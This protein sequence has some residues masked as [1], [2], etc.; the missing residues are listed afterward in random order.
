MLPTI[1]DYVPPAREEFPVNRVEWRIDPSR[2]VL[3]V[4]DMQQYFVDAYGEGSRAASSA[5]ANIQQLRAA[6]QEAGVPVYFT[7]QPP[8][9]RLED[10]RLLWDFWGPGIQDDGRHVIVDSL[11]PVAEESLITKWRYDAFVRTDLQERIQDAGRD[12]L[13]VTGIY[14]H[15]GVLMTA[16]SAFMRDIQPFLV[17]DAVADFSLDYHR[18]A[19]R[20]AAERCAVV[21]DSDTALEQL[22][23]GGTPARTIASGAAVSTT[24]S[25][26]VADAV[27]SGTVTPGVTP[28]DA[29]V[30]AAAS[31]G[32]VAAGAAPSSSAAEFVAATTST[33][34]ESSVTAGTV[35]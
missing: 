28:G 19:L 11:R 6:A 5:I 33:A 22:A 1:A 14:A 2:A 25:T 32:I 3:L 10:R 17:A 26:A 29:E 13:I 20:Y 12:Q 23:A 31:T 34:T 30:P 7:A 9:Q 24:S 15:I 16:I 27:V 35:A 21:I 4:H 8:S 18:E